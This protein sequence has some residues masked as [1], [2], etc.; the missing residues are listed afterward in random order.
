MRRIW[1]AI[2]VFFLCLFK[3]AVAEEVARILATDRRRRWVRRK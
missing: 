1:L 2:R 3:S